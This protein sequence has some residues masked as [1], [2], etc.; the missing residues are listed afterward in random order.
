MPLNSILFHSTL[1]FKML[2]TSTILITWLTNELWFSVGK[3]LQ[4]KNEECPQTKDPNRQS[5]RLLERFGKVVVP[6]IH[7]R[8]ILIHGG[9]WSGKLGCRNALARQHPALTEWGRGTEQDFMCFLLQH[10]MFRDKPTSSELRLL[11]LSSRKET[12]PP[13]G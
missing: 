9:S 6:N 12:S 3:I 4:W 1:L 7:P 13:L 11:E 5:Q 8:N 2:V 10:S